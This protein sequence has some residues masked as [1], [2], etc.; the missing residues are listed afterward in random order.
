MKKNLLYILM[1]ITLINCSKK[2]EEIPTLPLKKRIIGTWV[3]E[4]DWRNNDPVL[5]DSTITGYTKSYTFREDDS[6]V[7]IINLDS[8]GIS[9]STLQYSIGKSE[10][11]WTKELKDALI[12]HNIPNVSGDNLTYFISFKGSKMDLILAYPP[13]YYY[14]KYRKK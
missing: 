5:Y 11:Y 2:E 14:E 9:K 8:S 3:W 13:G 1:L 10:D 12:F 7:R 6:V 4:Y